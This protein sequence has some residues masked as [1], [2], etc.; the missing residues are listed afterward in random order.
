MKTRLKENMKE[1][2]INMEDREGLVSDYTVVNVQ[3]KRSKELEIFR[4]H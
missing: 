3:F 2:L 4:T 1:S